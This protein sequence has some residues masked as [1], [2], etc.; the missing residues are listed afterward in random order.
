M[1][2]EGPWQWYDRDRLSKGWAYPVGRDE[3]AT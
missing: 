3:V 2:D 1:A